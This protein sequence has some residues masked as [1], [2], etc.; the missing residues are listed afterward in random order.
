MA[1]GIWLVSSRRSPASSIAPARGGPWPCARMAGDEQAGRWQDSLPPV[2]WISGME[3]GLTVCCVCRRPKV[4]PRPWSIAPAV[5]Q[6]QDPAAAAPQWAQSPGTATAGGGDA[7]GAPAR[8]RMHAALGVYTVWQGRQEREKPSSERG[9][10]ARRQAGALFSLAPAPAMGQA[11]GSTCPSPWPRAS[12]C[13]LARTQ[14]PLH[15]A[16][17]QACSLP[18]RWCDRAGVPTPM[19]AA[20]RDAV[21]QLWLCCCQSQRPRG[22]GDTPSVLASL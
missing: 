3:Q 4:F 18:G 22:A 14:A 6:N 7:H 10:K 12:A 16:H 15:A 21:A 11:A 5:T 19:H 13:T 20:G 2:S 8:V 9:V 17:M 1:D